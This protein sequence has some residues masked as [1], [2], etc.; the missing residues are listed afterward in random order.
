[1]AQRYRVRT[2]VLA[3]FLAAGAVL[4]AQEA[5][6][7]YL[8]GPVDLLVDGHWAPADIGDTVP[9][10]GRVRLGEGAYLEVIHGN[11]TLRFDTAGEARID[12]AGPAASG[13]DVR[14]ILGTTFRR[15]TE[16]TTSPET[17]TVAAGVRASEAAAEPTIDWAGDESPAELIASGIAQ[18]RDGRVE[19]ASFDFQDAYEFATGADVDRAGYFFAYSLYM[20]DEL[21]SAAEVLDSIAPAPEA[22]YFTEYALL[23]GD[24]LARAGQPGQAVAVL[25]HLLDAHPAMADRDP[26]T[27]QLALFLLGEALRTTDASAAS[28]AYRRAAAVAPDTDVAA[29]ARSALQ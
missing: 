11:R 9:A 12:G 29:A 24:V 2:L 15:L 28:D 4:A 26:L 6:I 3:F 20:L 21:D 19:E 16:P 25:N 5:R 18:L 22:A 27:A 23:A 13:T 14:G 8:E 7:V 10:D 1:M 17:D